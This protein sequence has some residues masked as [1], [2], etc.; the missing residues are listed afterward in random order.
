MA[1]RE[2][3]NKDSLP[4]AINVNPDICRV[5]GVLVPFDIARDL[6]HAIK[7][8]P[9]V[10][11]QGVPLLFVTS[12]I[13]GVDGNQGQGLASGVAQSCGYVFVTG[14]AQQIFCNGL[15]VA[16]NMSE[17]EMNCTAAGIS[18]G[19]K[20]YLYTRQSSPLWPEGRYELPPGS[21]PEYAVTQTDYN[22]SD[23]ND[24]IT[25]INAWAEEEKY[26]ASSG[27]KP[28]FE[29]IGKGVKDRAGTW[30]FSPAVD[31]TIP[32]SVNMPRWADIPND[33]AVIKAWNEMYADLLKHE[34]GHI[35]IAHA[36]DQRI[37]SGRITGVG[38]TE[39]EAKED[40]KAKVIKKLDEI[41]KEIAAEHDLYDAVT[42]HGKAQHVA[43]GK[44]VILNCPA[45]AP[46][47]PQAPPP[48]ALP[49][50]G[51]P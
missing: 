46:T 27:Y 40:F 14:G 31:I 39:D 4:V 47:A 38:K 16:W 6:S 11:G 9:D 21:T 26:V 13:Q 43:G 42:N 20:G 22:F 44:D 3:A 18:N 23:C 19:T 2:L 36:F 41:E 15:A 45:P 8:S 28:V 12:V 32:A 7:H 50:G 35:K 34:E 17:C 10:T 24:V 29:A 49:P 30:T 37:D 51:R 33:P 48:G 1:V 5:D 25:K